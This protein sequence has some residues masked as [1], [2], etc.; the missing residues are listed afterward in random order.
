[1]TK[2]KLSEGWDAAGGKDA[3][4]MLKRAALPDILEIA[5][6]ELESFIRKDR[7]ATGLDVFQ[8]EQYDEMNE[9]YGPAEPQTYLC[10]V[11]VPMLAASRIGLVDVEAL[12]NGDEC[13]ERAVRWQGVDWLDR[14][15]LEAGPIV[16]NRLDVM[17]RLI[18]ENYP[19]AEAHLFK[20]MARE[21]SDVDWT[22]PMGRLQSEVAGALVDG[23]PKERMNALKDRG[24]WT[25]MVHTYD[26]E[27]LRTADWWREC[28]E[29]I[30]RV[31]WERKGAA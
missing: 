11:S 5:A 27:L 14:T 1:M 3:L 21:P 30:R 8:F 10:G 2:T 28:A 7:W 25:P 15:D 20:V 9:L 6:V 4:H 17:D 31:L 13:V 18:D 29:R 16:L 19:V 22:G 26:D 12:Y 23:E 24:L